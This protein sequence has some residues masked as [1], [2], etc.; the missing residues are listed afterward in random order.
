MDERAFAVA[1]L[2]A[3]GPGRVAPHLAQSVASR[4]ADCGRRLAALPDGRLALAWVDGS[5]PEPGDGL[6]VHRLTA[7]PLVTLAACL[8][9]CWVDVQADPYPGQATTRIAVLGLASG[10][11]ADL[12]H[13]TAALIHELPAIGLVTSD[14]EAVRLGPAVACWP[15]AQ[16]SLLRRSYVRLPDPGP[17]A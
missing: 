14:G 10:I 1:R 6:I 11:G 3:G 12:R 8:R 5:A 2:R 9:L 4:A 13:A 17:Q 7:V 16:V 15:T